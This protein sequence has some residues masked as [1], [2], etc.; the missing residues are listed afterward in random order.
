ML[1][2]CR[3]LSYRSSPAHYSIDVEPGS[4]YHLGIDHTGDLGAI[5]PASVAGASAGTPSL[6]VRPNP[7]VGRGTVHLSREGAR[8]SP[9]DILDC[10]GRLVRVLSE[11]TWDC[12]DA[13][14]QVVPGGVY[15]LRPE[16]RG[17]GTRLIVIR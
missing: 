5:D 17:E 4:N 12:R 15:L 3:T 10:A 11:E 7:Y 14:G 2:H 6:R 8:P 13:R 1:K 16:G 9:V